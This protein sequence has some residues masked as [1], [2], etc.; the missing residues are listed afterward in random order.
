MEILWHISTTEAQHSNFK[1]GSLISKWANAYPEIFDE[2]DIR[3]ARDQAKYGHKFYEW[4]GAVVIYNTIGYLSLMQEYELTSHKR[5][6]AAFQNI[7]DSKTFQYIM[8]PKEEENHCPD[9]FCFSVD[10]DD[11]FFC[12]VKGK[13]EKWDLD[14]LAFFK[15]LQNISG[16]AVRMITIDKQ[17]TIRETGGITF[18]RE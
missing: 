3:L 16:K 2:D 15:N 10:I 11:W 12:D 7:V 8:G 5:K 6:H 14:R 4:M 9:L 13:E 1:N 18:T 17:S